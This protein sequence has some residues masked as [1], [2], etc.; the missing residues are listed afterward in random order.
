MAGEDWIDM[1]IFE[2]TTVLDAGAMDSGVIF[3]H[4]NNKGSL[5]SMTTGIF[6]NNNTP[7]G[8]EHSN[9]TN[10]VNGFAVTS[11]LT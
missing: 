6:M 11:N 2:T 1:S 7:D 10:T 5:G 3:D 9:A 8:A 4:A